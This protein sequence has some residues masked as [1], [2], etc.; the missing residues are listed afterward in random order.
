MQDENP[1]ILVVILKFHVY[2]SCGTFN[3]EMTW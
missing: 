3:F 2:A 1:Q